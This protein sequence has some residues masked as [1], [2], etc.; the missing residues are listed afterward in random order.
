[1]VRLLPCRVDRPIW[2]KIVAWCVFALL[3]V[4]LPNLKRND[5]LTMLVLISYYLVLGWFLYHKSK[6]GLLYQL[7]YMLSMFA[8]QLIAIFLVV[9]LNQ[10]FTLENNLLFYLIGMFKSLFLMIITILLKQIQKKRYVEDQQNLKIKGMILVP[11]ISMVLIFLYLIGGDVFFARYGYE[12]LIVYCLLVIVINAYCL[13]FWY[14]VASNQQLKHRL[15][16]T[17]QQNELIHQYYEELEENYNQSRKI[18]HDIRNHINVLEQSQKMDQTQQ[19]FD[20]VH[21]M[22]NTLGLRFYT[23]N[24]MLNIVLNDKLKHILPEQV[25]CN[26]G[27]ICLDFITDVDITTIFS[28]LLD[29]ALEARENEEEFFIKIKGNQIHDFIVIKI[30]NPYSRDDKSKDSKKQGHQGIGLENVKQ[31]LEKY[32]GELKIEKQEKVFSVTLV[33]PGQ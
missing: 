28:N 13:Y 7:V 26:I 3:S 10:V 20:D 15:E 17:K 4:L 19:Y 21:A 6:M 2:I 32:Q 16:L 22:L 30:E 9:K 27:G 18:I 24:R 29:N 11:I 8:T 14:D 31:A 1:M 12:W 23:D 25:E 5:I 33:F